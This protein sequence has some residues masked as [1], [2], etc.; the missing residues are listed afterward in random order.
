MPVAS[1]IVKPLILSGAT[2]EM[3]FQT[4]L[5]YI[6]EKKM[7]AYVMWYIEGG[8]KKILVDTAIE[9]QQYRDYSAL[10]GGFEFEHIQTF[11][12]ALARVNCRPE[13]IDIVI[14]THLHFDHCMNTARC[15][16]AEVYVQEDELAFALDPHPIFSNVYRRSLFEDL[17]LKVVKGD[18]NLM[19]GIDL[20]FVPGH[21]P[22]CQGVLIQSPRGKVAISGFCSLS[23]NFHLPDDVQTGV[24]PFA[25]PAGIIPG[26]HTNPFQAYESLLKIRSSADIIIPL[27]DYEMARK[28]EI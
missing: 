24:S 11:E 12:Q 10:F 5:A 19:H 28:E 15:V 9:A 2:A 1:Y 3:S 14:Q 13:E 16:N 20:V 22:G 27:H 17:N 8:E 23:E 18:T 6:G 25:T 7:R 4:Y 21:S 26:I